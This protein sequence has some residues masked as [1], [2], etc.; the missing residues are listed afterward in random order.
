[1]DEIN[2]D[3]LLEIDAMRAVAD[4]LKGLDPQGRT[5][6]LN[7]AAAAFG[8]VALVSRDSTEPLPSAGAVSS[9]SSRVPERPT[10]A[11]ESIADLY[12]A[13][14]PSGDAEKALVGAYWFQVVKGEQDFD[15]QT[16]NRELKHLG[17]G[18]SNIT[19]ALNALISRKPQ[20]VIQT[21]KSGT[22]QQ[23]RKRYK[24]TTSGQQV[25]ERMIKTGGSTSEA[26]DA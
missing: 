3:P 11:F 7:W 23:A 25:A 17:H 13:A 1:M 22:S 21:R 14:Q 10:S 12:A 2:K 26:L 9:S 8:T 18:V 20:V 5:R 6:V 19:Q 4:A 16:I 15:S 24:L